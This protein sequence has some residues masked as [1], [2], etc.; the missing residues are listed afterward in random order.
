MIE[1]IGNYG[2]A[3]LTPKMESI[4]SAYR[5]PNSRYPAALKCRLSGPS[6]QPAEEMTYEFG[7][8]WGSVAIIL[9]MPA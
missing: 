3:I 2:L 9:F 7:K 5:F 8:V 1:D 4:L 6:G